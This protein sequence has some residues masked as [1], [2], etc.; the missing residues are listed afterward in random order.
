MPAHDRVAMVAANAENTTPTSGFDVTNPCTGEVI[1]ALPIHGAQYVEDEMKRIRSAA[2]KWA[3]LSVTQRCQRLSR[4]RDI[5]SQRSEEIAY[6]VSQENGKVI[7]D[8]YWLDV[9]ATLGVMNYFIDNGPRIL[10]PERLHLALLKHRRSYISY[11][12]KG[13]IGI[14]TPWNFPFFMPGSDVCMA[15]LAGNGVLLKPSESTPLSALI[16]KECYDEAGIDPDL[17]RVVTGFGET[18]AGLIS[19]KPDHVVFTGSVNVGRK[20]GV[21]CAEAFIPYTL[22]LGGKAPLLALDDADLERT[23]NAIVW[24]GFA[25]SGQICASVERVYASDE[26]YDTLVDRVTEK[27][28]ELR[29]GDSSGDQVVDLGALTIEQQRENA[30]RLVKDAVDKGA[31]LTT[32]GQAIENSP[33]LFYPPTV[34]A[35]CNHDMDVM[36]HEI[37][38]PV[39]PI[40]KVS[41]ET[42]AIRYANDSHLGLGAYVFTRDPDRGRRVAEQIEAGS[43]M[44]N[45]VVAHAGVAEM[46]WGGIKE[47]GFGFVR[48]DRGL[49]GLCHARHINEDRISISMSRDPN[50]YPYTKKGLD[51]VKTFAKNMLGGSLVAKFIRS[52][53]K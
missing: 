29:V 30:M 46:P 14:I 8:A 15:L 16:L 52:I 10:A 13:V 3:A 6:L 22:E 12:P 11:Q 35:D 47:S 4:A 2:P 48:S 38:G 9:V 19:S 25:N 31:R 24:G 41:S 39:V 17:F 26:I 37:F 28:K 7:H 34:L 53:L 40:M 27:T 51:G 49:Q 44:I 42:E 23:A 36:T 1:K 33:G 18:G 20:I 43:I 50:W 21:A 32:G 5:I 45:E